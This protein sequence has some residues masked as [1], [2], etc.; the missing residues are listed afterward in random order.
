M[1]KT[2]LECKVDSMQQDDLDKITESNIDF[3]KYTNQTV[4][5][6]GATGFIGAALV[7]SF[8]CISRKKQLPIKIIAAVRDE[9]KA[10]EIYGELLERKNLQ[11]YVGDIRNKITC[12]EKI[13]YIFHTASVTA[14][15]IMI[16][17]PVY[18]IDI[19]YL[20]TR[21]VLEYAKEKTVKGVVYV[22]SM[23]VYGKTDIN[24]KYITEEDLGYIDIEN[25]RSSYSEG[26]RICECLCTAYASE[27]QLPVKVARLAQTFGAGVQKSDTRVYAQFAKSVINKEDIVLH[28]DGKSEGNYCYIR[29][30]IQALMILGYDGKCGQAYNVVNE[31]NHMQI[32]EMASMVA[33]EIA[34][35]PI[36]V[37]FDIPE[38]SNQYGYAP[39]VKM[40]LCNEKMQKLGWMPT[41]GIKESYQRMIH[42]MLM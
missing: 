3:S 17:Q 30:V 8:L 39:S 33:N 21:N 22:S 36:K 7:K 1:K 40:H 24:K 4:F 11:L 6:T 12:D 38:E 42:D 41:V 10:N 20:G 2:E 32:R 9:R 29:D 5:I 16:Q 26:K 15:K 18:T 13:D 31:K 27:Y 28:T 23:E 34:D 25:V 35:S 14:S 19:A 37:I